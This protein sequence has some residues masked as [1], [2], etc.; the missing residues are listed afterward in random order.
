MI[1]IRNKKCNCDTARPTFGK[2]GDKRPSYC[3]LCKGDDMISFNSDRCQSACCIVHEMWDRPRA[4][5][6]VDGESLCNSCQSIRTCLNK[7]NFRCG[8]KF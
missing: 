7:A 8:L 1:D 2:P 4:Q 5:F 6:K 3:A